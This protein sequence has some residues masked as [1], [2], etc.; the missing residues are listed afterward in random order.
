MSRVETSARPRPPAAE[1]R[2]C[3]TVRYEIRLSE[4]RWNT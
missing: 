4:G 2:R 1:R 3:D